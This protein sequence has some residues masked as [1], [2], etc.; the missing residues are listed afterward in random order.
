MVKNP[1]AMQEMQETQIQPL[2]R[3]D[4]LEEGMATLSSILAWRILPWTEKPGG[5]QSIGL[6][7]VGR[8]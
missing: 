8:N 2:G 4:P 3:E 1:S 7:R 5:L 6:Q